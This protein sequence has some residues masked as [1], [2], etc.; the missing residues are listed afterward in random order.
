VLATVPGAIAAMASLL[1]DH[2]R[3][4]LGRALGPAIDY[5]EQGFPVSDL[6]EADLKSNA[7]RLSR[8]AE[9]SRILLP[10]GKV[11]RAGETLR[12]TDLAR[13]L[14]AIAETGAAAFYEGALAQRLVVG[15]KG[16]GGAIAAEDLAAHQTDR[17][18]PLTTSYR[19]Y[20]VY[21]QPP[22]S[23]GHVFMEE[24]AI[25]DGHELGSYAWRSADLVDLMVQTKMAAFADRD[26]FAGDPRVVDFNAVGLLD[27]VFIAGRRAVIQRRAAAAAAGAP[28]RSDTT[29][30]AVVDRDGNA[31]SLI[32]SVFSQFGAAA[33]V[34]ETGVL[35]NNRLLGFSRIPD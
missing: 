26:A 28:L 10:G 21:G 15:I 13:S 17:G 5:A 18:A 4:D 23:Q 35:L 16:L 27:P 11:P 34:P 33:I 20:T 25:A 7:S 14:R 8:D 31:V 6:L 22:P 3:F 29:Y 12:Q 19:G 2:G 32:E 1:R 30:L 9:C 24:L